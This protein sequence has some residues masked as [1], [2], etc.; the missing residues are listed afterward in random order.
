MAKRL[1]NRASA[2]RLVKTKLCATKP[3]PSA[4][5]RSTWRPSWAGASLEELQAAVQPERDVGGGRRHPE[6]DRPAEG[7]D[8]DAGD[9]RPDHAAGLP[10][11]GAERDR[12]RGAAPAR[13]AAG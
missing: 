11:D 3:S 7:G 5:C 12:I 1:L 9:G 8:E 6:A 4:N 10:R 13:R 2:M